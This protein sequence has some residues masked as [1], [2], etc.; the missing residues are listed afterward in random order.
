MLKEARQK[1]L[2]LGL[3]D[4]RVRCHYQTGEGPRSEHMETLKQPL[5]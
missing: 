2:K 4:L 5:S 3:P 1:Y